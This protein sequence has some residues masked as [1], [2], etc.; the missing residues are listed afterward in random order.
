MTER[1]LTVVVR[2]DYPWPGLRFDGLEHLIWPPL[3]DAPAL[4][5]FV[6]KVKA[7]P[8]VDRVDAGQRGEIAT[9]I[10][11]SAGICYCTSM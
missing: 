11:H 8:E 7:S 6:S 4:K 1:L 5:I 3:E 9:C 2:A 10:G